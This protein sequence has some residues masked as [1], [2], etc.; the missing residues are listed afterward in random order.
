M[1]IGVDFGGTRIKTA[2][3]VDGEI[4]QGHAI[5]TPVGASPGEFV[6]RIAAEVHALAPDPTSVGLAV[7]GQVDSD[8]MVWRMPNVPGF[9][10]FHI[11]R[12]LGRRVGCPVAVENDATTAALGEHL[13]GR[14]RG[15][16]SFLMV[17]LGTGIGGGLVI[18]NTLCRGA[19]GFAGE[20]GHV[21]IDSS[22]DAA[23]CSCGK[24]GCVEAYAGTRALLAKYAKLGGQATRVRDIAEAA[25]RGE[26]AALEVFAQQGRALGSLLARVQSLVD[27]D[28]V[29][30]SGGVSAAFDLFE[31]SLRETLTAQV[32]AAPLGQIPL[33][34]SQL[35]ARAGL[36]GAAYLPTLRPNPERAIDDY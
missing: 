32:F 23:L 18:A 29:V 24:R 21:N 31:P 34:V 5:D 27:L 26:S 6:E 3:V 4:T 15:F 13:W 7:P 30:F 11:G 2:V 25:R 28:A 36:V 17:T 19:H 8:G 14:G 22:L 16:S 35:G 12:E 1:R 20:V 9:E 10:A 33:V